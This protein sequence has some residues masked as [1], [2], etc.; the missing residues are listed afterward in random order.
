MSHLGD[1]ALGSTFD[2]KFTTVNTSGVPTTLA[3]TPVVSAY[4][5]NSTTE[6]TAGITLTVD[7]DARTGLH[8]VRVV[9]TS[10]NGYAAGSNY[11]LVITT[12]TVGGSSVVGYVIAEFSIEARSALRPTVAG[13][14]ADVAATGEMGLDFDNIKDATGA[15][16]LTNIRVPNVTLTDTLTTYTGN[17]PQTG[18]SFA[19]LGAPAGV[20][21]SADIA[22]INSKLGAIAGG[23]LNTVLGYFRALVAKAAALT[24]TDL[25][26]GTTFDNT[27]HST[28]AIRDRGDAAWGAGA[29]PSVAAI[30]DGVWDELIAGHLA[31]GSTGE[32]LNSRASQASV[33]LLVS[34]TPIDLTV[35]QTEIHMG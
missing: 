2:T 9:A 3:G 30:A 15:H 33:D 27:L 32:K 18:D 25:S 8:N 4:V 22:T 11:Q 20:S 24:P 23:G 29:V 31:A 6:L 5:D 1:F 10:G 7:F 14:T 35:E 21:V 34:G 28:E 13:R 19:R 12:G 16:T 17:T 26:T